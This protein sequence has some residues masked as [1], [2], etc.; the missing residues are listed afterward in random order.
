[1]DAER[2]HLADIMHG[3]VRKGAFVVGAPPYA[4]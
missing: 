3:R 2:H 4:E 1:M